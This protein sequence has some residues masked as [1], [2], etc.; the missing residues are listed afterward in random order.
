MGRKHTG[1]HGCQNRGYT[2]KFGIE[3]ASIGSTSDLRLEGWLDPLVVYIIPVNVSEKWLAHDLLSICGAASE[4]LVGL[5]C[6][7]LL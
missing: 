4:T 3:I 7:Q 1:L 6:E 5:S 2:R